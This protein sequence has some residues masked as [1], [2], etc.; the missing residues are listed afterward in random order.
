MQARTTTIV[1]NNKNPQAFPAYV[2]VLASGL[3]HDLPMVSNHFQYSK[4]YCTTRTRAHHRYAT[5]NARAGRPV[6]YARAVASPVI[7]INPNLNKKGKLLFQAQ[8][9]VLST[10]N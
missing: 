3:L 2:H 6:A 9:L 5:T 1:T 4:Y 8:Q 7:K 10:T